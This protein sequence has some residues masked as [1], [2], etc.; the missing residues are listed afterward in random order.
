MHAVP[1]R[2]AMAE[3]AQPPSL[4]TGHAHASPLRHSAPLHLHQP[5]AASQRL[6]LVQLTP[7]HA[8][9]T[10]RLV[11]AQVWPTAHSSDPHRH[12]LLT[13]SQRSFSPQATAVQLR[14][15]TQVFAFALHVS[16]APQT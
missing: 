3:A 7:E 5:S 9:A 14:A 16:F 1:T 4:P 13:E 11:A 8:S 6:P 10:Q 15:A 12:R 2:H